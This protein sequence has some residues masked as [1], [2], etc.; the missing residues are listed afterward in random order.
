MRTDDYEI[1][2]SY[3]SNLLRNVGTNHTATIE[4]LFSENPKNEN[5]F[6]CLLKKRINSKNEK[7]DVTW[8][9]QKIIE[10]IEEYLQHY[11]APASTKQVIYSALYSLC[12]SIGES[13][14]IPNYKTQLEILPAP[15]TGDFKTD[16]I[17]ALH[18]QEGITKEDFAAKYHVDPKT[19]QNHIHAL[20]GNR[21]K[22][23]RIA[24]FFVQGPVSSHDFVSRN[25]EKQRY[26][27]KNTINPIMFLTNTTQTATL[28]QSLHLNYRTGNIIP[29]EMA[30]DIWC[31][32]SDY[33]KDKIKSVFCRD[34]L[35]FTEF[36][37]EIEESS[38]SISYRHM[39]EAELLR[40]GQLSSREQLVLAEKGRYPCD[41]RLTNPIRSRKRHRIDYDPMREIY[42]AVSVDDPNA[43]PLEFR[44]SELLYLTISL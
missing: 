14:D 16:L 40:E 8:A 43:E 37:D 22:P 27:M 38:K 1:K 17:K 9:F 34:D 44:E 12:A 28:L 41:I 5:S 36:I 35:D 39:T 23:L 19:V 30:I 10:T 33:T 20:S 13:Y 31:Q 25:K 24:G 21:E 42:F 18:N 4:R 32:L 3:I 15:V 2:Y 7:I 26:Y 29:Q 11:H 6:L